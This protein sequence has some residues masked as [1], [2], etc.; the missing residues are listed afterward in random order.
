MDKQESFNQYVKKI[1]GKLREL[2]ENQRSFIFT[3]SNENIERLSGSFDVVHSHIKGMEKILKEIAEDNGFRYIPG[4][5]IL[6]NYYGA[7][8]LVKMGGG[9]GSRDPGAYEFQVELD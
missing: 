6:K 8:A 5:Y 9:W 2:S 7:M 3:W 1:Q 4:E